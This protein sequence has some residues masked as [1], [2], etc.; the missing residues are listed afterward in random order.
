[1]GFLTL[2]TNMSNKTFS[3]IISLFVQ[4]HF[5]YYSHPVTPYTMPYTSTSIHC[6]SLAH[7]LILLHVVASRWQAFTC[8]SKEAWKRT[9]QISESR[10][11]KKHIHYRRV[12]GNSTTGTTTSLIL[13]ATLAHP[14]C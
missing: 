8:K 14:S 12:G 7:S 11:E 13:Y 6:C 4:T 10:Q 3:E 9:R 1:M 2:D 5:L